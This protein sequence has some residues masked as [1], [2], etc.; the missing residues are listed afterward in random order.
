MS[1]LIAILIAGELVILAVVWRL[2]KDLIKEISHTRWQNEGMQKRLHEE[3][4]KVLGL[5]RLLA[6]LRK[7]K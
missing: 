7:S 1:W 2:G 5:E 6:D 3:Q 4:L